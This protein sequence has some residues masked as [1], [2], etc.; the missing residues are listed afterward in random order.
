MFR[1]AVHVRRQWFECYM[2]RVIILDA[3]AMSSVCS[4]VAMLM[5]A[6]VW[7]NYISFSKRFFV[8]QLFGV[9]S[10]KTGVPFNR[11]HDN[12]GNGD[13]VF[14]RVCGQKLFGRRRHATFQNLVTRFFDLLKTANAFD[15]PGLFGFVQF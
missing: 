10:V 6:M 3:D 11:R 4:P 14:G 8:Q 12:F 7:N 5:A 13:V 15:A 9:R 1:V 2:T